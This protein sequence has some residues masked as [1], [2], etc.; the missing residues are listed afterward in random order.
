MGATTDQVWAAKD[1]YT[2]W[3]CLE[4]DTCLYWHTPQGKGVRTYNEIRVFH[5][6]NEEGRVRRGRPEAPFEEVF[7]EG[8]QVKQI[9][10][11]PG[12]GVLFSTIWTWHAGPL[13][14]KLRMAVAMTSV[15]GT[16]RTAEGNRQGSADSEASE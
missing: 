4:A 3:L 9:K 15:K 7:R 11:Q 14:T 13:T 10:L 12:Q 6:T 16:K 1:G 8:K 5:E 2:L